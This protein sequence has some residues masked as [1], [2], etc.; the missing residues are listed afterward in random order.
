MNFRLVLFSGIVTALI[1]AM[2][3]LAATQLG[4]RNFN[5]MRFRSEAYKAL[6][7]RYALIGA[8]V[9]FAVGVGQECVRELKA[10]QE[11]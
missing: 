8:G 10:Q 11:D 2:I 6:Y 7:G 1:G 9:G 3:G 5:Q 4:Q